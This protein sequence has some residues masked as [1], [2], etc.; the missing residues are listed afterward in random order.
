[1][2]ILE[3]NWL[4]ARGPRY[5]PTT[6][7]HD[8]GGSLSLSVPGKGWSGKP[9]SPFLLKQPF[10]W[11]PNKQVTLTLLLLAGPADS[12][13]VSLRS[14]SFGSSPPSD[15]TSWPPLPAHHSDLLCPVL[16]PQGFC[17]A[18]A[19]AWNTHPQGLC[20][21]HS[22]F[23]R[24]KATSSELLPHPSPSLFHNPAH[25]WLKLTQFYCVVCLLHYRGA[26]VSPA[27][28]ATPACRR[29]SVFVGKREENKK[30]DA[31]SRRNALWLFC[32]RLG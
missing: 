21:D 16:F 23:F 13:R 3:R 15:I 17:T 26:P 9:Q 1:M 11:P 18:C 4:V 25:R 24:S 8:L 29:C 22:S 2:G 28:R 5:S 12:P 27:P 30:K 7:L 32:L 20:L 10:K 6:A 19:P 31:A 14:A